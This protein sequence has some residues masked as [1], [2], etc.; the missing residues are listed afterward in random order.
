MIFFIY[1][2]IGIYVYG[3]VETV[4]DNPYANSKCDP[5]GFQYSWGD[6]KYA[7]FKSFSGAY[8]MIL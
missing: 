3:N 8:L 7:D 5:N 6:C 2:N 4:A 1:A